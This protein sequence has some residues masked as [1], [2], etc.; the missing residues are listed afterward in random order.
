MFGQVVPSVF[1]GIGAAAGLRLRDGGREAVQVQDLLDGEE[2]ARLLEPRRER[3][4]V[5][6]G[7]NVVVL[8]LP[9]HQALTVQEIRLLKVDDIDLEKATV[10]VPSTNQTNGRKLQLAAPQVMQL[11]GYQ[12]DNRP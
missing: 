4:E 6:A 1:A 12:S 7:Q 9:V 3:Y 2:L 8:G 11:H 5:L 10:G